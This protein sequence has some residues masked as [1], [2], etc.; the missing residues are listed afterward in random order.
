MSAVYYILAE[1]EA[2]TRKWILSKLAPKKYGDRAQVDIGN[3]NDKPFVTSDAEAA[4]KL[5]AII[6]AGQQRKDNAEDLI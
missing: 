4:T 6:A 5:A 3:A 2:D 1:R